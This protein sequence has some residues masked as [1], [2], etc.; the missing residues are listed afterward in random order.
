MNAKVEGKSESVVDAQDIWNLY[1][2]F[3]RRDPETKA[4]IQINIGRPFSDLFFDLLRSVEFA[5]GVLSALTDRSSELP[6]YRGTVQLGHIVVWA[7]A[8]L[9]VRV[10]LRER[11]L[12]ARTWSELDETLFLDPELRDHLP[13]LAELK[14]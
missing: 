1:N 4:T 14:A 5:N 3:L 6:P 12:R 13:Q 11:L 10:E 9:P 8:R 7:H 2:L